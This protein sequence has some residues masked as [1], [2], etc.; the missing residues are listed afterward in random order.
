MNK[1]TFKF[2]SKGDRY[3]LEPVKLLYKPDK[4]KKLYKAA[5]IKREKERQQYLKDQGLLK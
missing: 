2:T 1:P 3:K 5:N 4:V